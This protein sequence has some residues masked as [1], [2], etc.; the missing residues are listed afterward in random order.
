MEP[1]ED[2][3]SLGEY[4]EEECGLVGGFDVPVDEANEFCLAYGRYLDQGDLAEAGEEPP[5]ALEAVVEAAPEFLA[6][7][8]RDALREL[9]RAAGR[10]VPDAEAVQVLAGVEAIY[11]VASSMCAAG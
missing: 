11:T 8:G 7:A 10:A 3:V 5:R 6:E 2:G 4:A 9:R 1:D